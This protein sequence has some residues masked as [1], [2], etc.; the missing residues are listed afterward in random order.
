M[1][2]YFADEPVWFTPTDEMR[3]WDGKDIWIRQ[4][5]REWPAIIRVGDAH[6]MSEHREKVYVMAWQTPIPDRAFEAVETMPTAPRR[7]EDVSLWKQYLTQDA[8]SLI[9]R[10]Y[11]EWP[12]NVELGLDLPDEPESFDS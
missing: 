1:S 11:A 5:K 2:K 4:G 8:M 6:P 12:E 9:R 3:S 10:R 7:Y